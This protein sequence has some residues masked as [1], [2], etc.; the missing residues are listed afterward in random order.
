M[1]WAT[2]IPLINFGIGFLWTLRVYQLVGRITPL[3]AQPRLEKELDRAL[4]W[5]LFHFA[6]GVASLIT[7]AVLSLI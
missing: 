3:K 6:F 1:N 4:L 2:A 5:G 7:S